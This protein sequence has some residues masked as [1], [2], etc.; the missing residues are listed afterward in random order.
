MASA[1]RRHRMT[2]HEL[3]G[4]T[5]ASSGHRVVYGTPE[6]MADN[7]QEWHASAAV[8][9]FI[10]KTT[11]Y[12][13]PLDNYVDRVVPSAYGARL[14]RTMPP[15]GRAAHRH[16]A[17]RCQRSAWRLNQG[18]VAVHQHGTGFVHAD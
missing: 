12:S 15:A 7:L 8:D 10:I 13:A 14:F 1:A 5:A 6:M 11:H 18:S 3:R 9:G 2:I 16:D 17:C 4:Y